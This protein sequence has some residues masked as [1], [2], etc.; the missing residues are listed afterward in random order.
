MAA[1]FPSVSRGP[2]SESMTR[3]RARSTH[4]CRKFGKTKPPHAPGQTPSRRHRPHAE[5]QKKREEKAASNITKRQKRQNNKTDKQPLSSHTPDRP[6]V[7]ANSA[8]R[9]A[10]FRCRT[11]GCGTVRTGA[12]GVAESA[13]RSSRP[14]GHFHNA[15]NGRRAG[16]CTGIARRRR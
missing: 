15:G 16:A 4:G 10:T 7:G 5:K 14:I 6:C 13:A 1:L 11:F 2:R 9:T 12:V 3:C 8:L